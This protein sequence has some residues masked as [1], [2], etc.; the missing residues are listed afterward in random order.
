[1][2]RIAIGISGAGTPPLRHP[3][4]APGWHE[5]AFFVRSSEACERFESRR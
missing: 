2:I 5:L 4:L 1:M 3:D